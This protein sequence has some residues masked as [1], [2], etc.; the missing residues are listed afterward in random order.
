[1]NLDERREHE[2]SKYVWLAEHRGPGYGSSNHAYKSGAIQYVKD[3]EY[4][5]DFGCGDNGFLR[6]SGLAGVGIDFVN[7][8]AD[9]IAGMHDVPVEDDVADLVTSFDALEHLLP[10]EVDEVLQEMQRVAK[11]G[12]DLIFTICSQPSVIKAFGENLHP[13]VQPPSWWIE[14]IGKYATVRLEDS[15]HGQI[16]TGVWK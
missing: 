11:T 1:M 16:Y 13:T 10:E 9:I 8:G 5:V 12:A 3:P 2:K 4:T 15:P 14:T 6:E 7:Q